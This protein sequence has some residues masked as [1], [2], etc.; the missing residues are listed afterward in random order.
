MRAVTRRFFVLFLATVMVGFLGVSELQAGSNSHAGEV[1]AQPV[2]LDHVA[3]AS[4]AAQSHAKLNTERFKF[5]PSPAEVVEILKAG[6]S[7]FISG[8]S[9]HPHTDKKRLLKAGSENQSDYALATVITCSDSRV[10]VERVFDAGVMDLF[11]I[12]VAGNVCDTDEIGSIEYGLAHVNT[13]VLVVLGHTQCGAVTAVTHALQGKG[14]ALE[15]NIPKLVDNIAPAVNRAMHDHPHAEGDALVQAGI[16][17][18][19]WQSI[20]DLFS[21][22]PATRELV[23]RGFVK[24]VGALY[25]VGSG[26]IQWLDESKS[27]AILAK[28]ESDPTRA[29]NVFAT[30]DEPIEKVAQSNQ[31]EHA[32]LNIERFTAKPSADQAIANLQAGNSRFV[33]GVSEHPHTDATR[34][35]QAGSE[36]QGD[37]AYATVITCS[38]SRIPV[39]RVFDAGVMDLF[40]V[41]VAGNVCDIDEIG[42]IEYGL[43][44]VNTP[45]LVVL[46]HS[47][48]GAVTAVTHAVQGKGH[49]LERNI[50]RL[51][52]NIAPAVKKAMHDHPHAQGTALIDAG[53]E[54]NVWQSIEDLFRES[55]Q[56]RELV[57]R[58]LV[59][60]VGAIYNV[61]TGEVEWLSQTKSAAILASFPASAAGP[62]VAAKTPVGNHHASA[63]AGHG[64]GHGKVAANAGHGTA[65]HAAA[66]HG[67]TV[68]GNGTL[69]DQKKFADIYGRTKQA[70]NSSSYDTVSLDYAHGSKLAMV[71]IVLGVLLLAL[72]IGLT[73]TGALNHVKIGVKLYA[74][75]GCLVALL[76]GIWGVAWYYGSVV[77]G[78]VKQT[79]QVSQVEQMVTEMGRLEN[80]FLL[81]GIEDKQRGDE[82]VEQHL[83]LSTELTAKLRELHAGESNVQ[84]N[85][86][87]SEL[88]QLIGTYMVKF[89]TVSEKFH[90]IEEIK[91]TSGHAGEKIGQ[92]LETI[93]HHHREQLHQLEA[94]SSPNVNKIAQ[95]AELIMML[96]ES[97]IHWLKVFSHQNEYMLDGQYRHVASMEEQLGELALSLGKV[98]QLIDAAATSPAEAAREMEQIQEVVGIIESYTHEASLLI[99]DNLQVGFAAAQSYQNVAQVEA[100]AEGLSEFYS[101]KMHSTESSVQW[102]ELVMLLTAVV[103]GLVLSVSIAR[104]IINPVEAMV[105]NLKDIAEGEGDLTKRVD[106]SRRDE[107]GSLGKWFNL[108]VVKIHGVMVTVAEASNEV[109]AAATEIAASSD[110]MAMGMSEQT[111]QVTQISAAVE[112]MSASVVEVARKSADAARNAE[113]SGRVAGEGGDVVKDT[114]AGMEAISEAVKAGAACVEELGKRGDQIGEIIEV[115]NDIADQTN[116]LALNAAIEAA[117]A[118]EHGRGFAVVAD[119]VRKLADRTTQATEE[120]GQSIK[121]IQNETGQ[122][123]QQ[124]SV[125]TDQVDVGVRKATEAGESLNRIVTSAREVAGMI[126]TIAA[127]AEEQSATSE[128]VS[129]NVESIATVTRQS[130]EGTT[131]AAQA[132]QSLS[133][134]AE[135]L[136]A[137]IGQFRL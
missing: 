45:V 121:A 8:T 125:G 81:Y 35:A 39:E 102:V 43:A 136:S 60:V 68:A 49:A 122:A 126:Q 73:W 65:S 132:A 27:D 18:N 120:I 100:I 17:S 31:V 104:S 77:D 13:P 106:E 86:A 75:H 52:D 62:G 128:E 7:R 98:R 127:A 129:R 117:R 64:S 69:I 1:H 21:E 85:E 47:Q 97:E 112:E 42:S 25:D 90:E 12:R 87:I 37:H 93:I 20:E 3:A 15:R 5:K 41:R 61:G 109:A 67:A 19:V 82:S 107:L 130:S 53:I 113:E 10:P 4:S 11:N 101:D 76:I 9:S 119:E 134:K 110:Q 105:V 84:A 34:L 88:E 135:Q 36:N 48:C 2:A 70:W 111:S 51:V 92:T 26:Q 131:Q 58:G 55:P 14:H 16:E 33:S 108:F 99:N 30:G 29:R 89:E 96:E 71:V 46:G 57:R 123:V 44:H 32:P 63:N 28:V 118:G 91:E 50:P 40:V 24:V 80:E 72:V 6:N 137:L 66:G 83:D 78:V 103:V 116:L 115:I 74:S 94:V 124:M 114:I 95:V 54:A 79:Q 133:A 56:T 23:K 22:S 38:D 59:K